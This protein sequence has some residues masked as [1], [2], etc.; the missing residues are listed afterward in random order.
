MSRSTDGTDGRGPIDRR[1]ILRHSMAGF[2]II[3]LGARLGAQGPRPDPP[4]REED[5][6]CSY[7]QDVNE[8]DCGTHDAGGLL[9]VDV[10][11]GTQDDDFDQ[12]CNQAISSGGQ[13]VGQDFSCTLSPPDIDCG[14]L[15]LSSGTIHSDSG[16]SLSTGSDAGCGLNAGLG[17]V[18]RDNHCGAELGAEDVDCGLIGIGGAPEEDNRRV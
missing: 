14:A 10:D 8:R 17:E 11:C 7:A 4:C 13:T 2:A 3:H 5:N 6:Q 12:S 18:H 1:S 15:A 16:C 9:I